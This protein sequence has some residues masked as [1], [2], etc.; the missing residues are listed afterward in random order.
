[1][2]DSALVLYC[3]RVLC[4]ACEQ[5]QFKF[6]RRM[7]GGP[8]RG[9]MWCA[10]MAALPLAELFLTRLDGVFAYAPRDIGKH[11][12]TI[13]DILTTARSKQF[14]ECCRQLNLGP[15]SSDLAEHP[16]TFRYAVALA[17]RPRQRKWRL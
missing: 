2:V 13:A 6:S 1:K 17:R 8:P 7:N 5:P 4:E 15:G 10:L 16:A 12:E 14:A 3:A 11:A 9:P